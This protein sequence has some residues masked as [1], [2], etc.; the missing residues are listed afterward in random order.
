MI[1]NVDQE[2]LKTLITALVHQQFYI[3]DD[4][5]VDRMK[6]TQQTIA[7]SGEIIQKFIDTVYDLFAESDYY[8]EIIKRINKKF[9]LE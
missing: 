2:E 8:S 7:G 5:I 6:H 4:T 3:G 1:E 9:S